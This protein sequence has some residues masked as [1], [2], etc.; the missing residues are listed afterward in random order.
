MNNLTVR[1]SLLGRSVFDDIF[2][3]RKDFKKL[4]NRTTEGYPVT[5]IYDDNDGNTIMEFA[6]A[7]FTKEE[8]SIEVRPE[9]STITVKASSDSSSDLPKRIARRSFEKTYINYDSHL[10]LKSTMAE[11]KNGLLRVKVPPRAEAQS[12]K[13]D[14]E[15]V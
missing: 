9:D 13:V 11:Y 7:G 12:V 4:L 8:L 1:P 10:D 2:L 3:T 6:L 14:I 15:S 5:D